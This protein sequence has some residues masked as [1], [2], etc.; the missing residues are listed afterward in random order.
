MDTPW[1]PVADGLELYLR[2][3]PNAGTT[4]IENIEIRDDGRAVLRVRVT[5]VPDKGKANKAVIALI[6]E[7]F[8]IAKSSVT[9]KSGESARQK[10][11][12]LQGD[13]GELAARAKS[14][15]QSDA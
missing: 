14:L 1:R 6:A 7:K 15:F 3:T 4:R 2:V 12:R 11:L 5:A 13:P 10:V 8:G 9:L